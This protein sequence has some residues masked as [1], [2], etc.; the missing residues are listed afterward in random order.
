MYTRSNLNHFVG[1]G[2]GTHTGSKHVFIV[3]KSFRPTIEIESEL[4]CGIHWHLLNDEPRKCQ[5]DRRD[6]AVYAAISIEYH[7]ANLLNPTTSFGT[8]G[9]HVCVSR[10]STGAVI[11]LISSL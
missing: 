4:L 2:T 11:A 7:M 5:A 9:L 8:P 3:P 1:G 10:I 6:S